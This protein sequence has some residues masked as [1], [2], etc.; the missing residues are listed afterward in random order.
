MKTLGMGE[1]CGRQSS[2][3]RPVEKVESPVGSKECWIPAKRWF[4]NSPELG[5]IVIS[6]ASSTITY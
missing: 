1:N 3:L 5:L 6:S 2:H 4:G